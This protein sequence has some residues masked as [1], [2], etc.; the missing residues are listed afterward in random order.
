MLLGSVV[1]YCVNGSLLITTANLITTFGYGSRR[2]Q[3]YLSYPSPAEKCRRSSLEI[4]TA[5]KYAEQPKIIIISLNLHKSNSLPLAPA[6]TIDKPMVIPIMKALLSRM[7]LREYGRRIWQRQLTGFWL[8]ARF[9][10]PVNGLRGEQS[11][12]WVGLLMVIYIPCIIPC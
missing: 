3:H 6:E 5:Q 2:R 11:S 1:L 4:N 8:L 10:A 7:L 12:L 9:F